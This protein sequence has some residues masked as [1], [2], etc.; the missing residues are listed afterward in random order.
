MIYLTGDTHIPIDIS[1]LNTTNFPEQREMMREDYVI[2]L[3][4]FGLLWHDDK[5]YH[6]WLKWL[7][8]KSFTI[9]WLDGNHENHEWIQ[10][11]PAQKW[12]GGNVHFI[13]DNIIHLMRGQIY[14]L[15]G[16][17]FFVMGGAMSTDKARRRAGISW[18]EQEVPSVSEGMQ[19][20]DRLHHYLL[21]GKTIDYV[22]THTCPKEIIPQMFPDADSIDDPTTKLLDAINHEVEDTMQGWYFGHWHEDKTYW[23]YHCLYDNIERII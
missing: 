14:D 16:N 2:V 18:W 11:L 12:H 13:S 4:D 3:G 5:E 15:Q 23:K 19:A 6:H 20:L 22:L 17:S 10:S 21:S 8:E 9:L 1:K 7:C